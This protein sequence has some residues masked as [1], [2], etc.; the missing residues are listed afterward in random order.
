V[1]IP[2]TIAKV[3][4]IAAVMADGLRHL[5]SRLPNDESDRAQKWKNAA[6][7]LHRLSNTEPCELEHNSVFREET[8][9]GET[10][11]FFET[12]PPIVHDIREEEPC[13]HCNCSTTQERHTRLQSTTE[14]PSEERGDAAIE[15][16]RDATAHPTVE[17]QDPA[18]AHPTVENQDPAAAHPVLKKQE[19]AAAHPAGNLVP[20]KPN[21]HQPRT[22]S[23]LVGSQR[24][25]T[26]TPCPHAVSSNED[27]ATRA[28]AASL[29]T[30]DP[31]GNTVATAPTIPMK[32]K[33]KNAAAAVTTTLP[34]ADPPLDVLVEKTETAV[35]TPEKVAVWNR[36]CNRGVVVNLPQSSVRPQPAKA[37][38]DCHPTNLS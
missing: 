22:R 18:T 3:T 4:E 31:G 10:A 36:S 12:P 17:S 9:F 24:E 7:Q 2:F 25:S 1:A 16:Q 27:I 37:E 20:G 33:T 26:A 29:T 11:W 30:D 32:T 34:T 6:K 8:N 23:T 15:N 28:K 35:A 38:P 5:A 14:N 21:R 19:T 13:H